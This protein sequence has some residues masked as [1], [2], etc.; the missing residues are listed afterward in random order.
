MDH[1]GSA[2]DYGSY[3]VDRG[4]PN[5]RC[6]ISA[7]EEKSDRGTPTIT[8][9]PHTSVPP[10]RGDRNGSRLK[11]PSPNSDCGTDVEETGRIGRAM[12][13]QSSSRWTGTTGWRFNTF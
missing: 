3:I 2:R 5:E 12:R 8:P 11:S 13:F 4:S 7:L 10:F 9:T 1:L 6:L